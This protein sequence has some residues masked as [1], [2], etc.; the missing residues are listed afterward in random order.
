VNLALSLFHRLYNNP[1]YRNSFWLMAGSFVM[2]G[3]GF[4]YWLL[5]ARLY[6]PEQIGLAATF[7]SVAAI[8]NLVA[9]F[10]FATTLIRYLPTSQAKDEK[11]NTAFTVI[12]IGATLCGIIY[13]LG[14]NFWTVQLKFLKGSLPAIIFVLL[15][16]PINI[17]NTATDSIFTAFRNAKWVFISNSLQSVIKLIV[18]ILLPA[19]GFWG[20]VGSN[21]VGISIAVAT[22]LYFIH[23]LYQIR[24]IP[25]ID[26]VIL[27][28]VKRYTFGNYVSGI[29]S[30]LPSLLLPILITNRI[31]P[32]QTAYFYMPNMISSLLI[33]I[34][35]MISRSYLTEGSY[36][37]NEIAIRKPLIFSYSI[38][39]PTTIGLVVFGEELL[40]LFGKNYAS[41]GYNYLVL[42]SLSVLISVVNYFLGTRLLIQQRIKRLIIINILTSSFYLIASWYL[43]SAGIVGIGFA[44]IMTQLLSLLVLLILR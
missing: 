21:I 22:S 8:I 44:A 29:I 38:M 6:T 37:E 14:I 5:A 41:A 31:S 35:A 7:L 30:G 4:I 19:L 17:I 16:F 28:Q 40:K 27:N 2:A 10:G 12:I 26:H 18:L 43:S 9:M 1:L 36:S 33:I 34:P 24:F 13:L 15:Y 42:I 32:E 25:K 23:H 20:I 3:V 39:I 11:I